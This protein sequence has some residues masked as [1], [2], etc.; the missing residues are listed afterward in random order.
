M[1]AT[2]RK[3][4]SLARAEEDSPPRIANFPAREFSLRHG[5]DSPAPR[6]CHHPVPGRLTFLLWIS[7]L[8]LI[9]Q[10]ADG[11]KNGTVLIIRHAEKPADGPGLTPRGEERAKAYPRYFRNF[12]VDGKPLHLDRIFAAADSDESQR[13]RLTVLPLARS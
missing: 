7:L 6:R 11:P 1:A 10:A 4:N 13:P 5:L 2:S 3:G 12:T 8:S 9:A